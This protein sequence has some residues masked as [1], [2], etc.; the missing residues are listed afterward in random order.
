MLLVIGGFSLNWLPGQSGLLSA[1][2]L[3]AY[4]AYV[5]TVTWLHFLPWVS[6]KL[7]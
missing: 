6:A 5:A 7:S 3:G 2:S 1:M 4:L